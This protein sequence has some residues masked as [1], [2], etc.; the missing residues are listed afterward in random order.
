[1]GLS[2]TLFCPPGAR[3]FTSIP[4]LSFLF[5]ISARRRGCAFLL[6]LPPYQHFCLISDPSQITYTPDNVSC[7]SCTHTACTPVLLHCPIH[8]SCSPLALRD[9]LYK[10]QL[11]ATTERPSTAQPP[12]P[13]RY[14]TIK[15]KVFPPIAETGWTNSAR[16]LPGS[17]PENSLAFKFELS[18]VGDGGGGDRCPESSCL[19]LRH[20]RRDEH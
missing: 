16:A 15:V 13:S 10:S 6:A 3:T 20:R 8:C 5:R 12:R 2:R 4:S 19:S 1:M 7:T 11:L 14:E 18:P 17:R 9:K